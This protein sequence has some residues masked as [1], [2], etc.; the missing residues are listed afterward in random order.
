MILLGCFEILLKEEIIQTLSTEW[1]QELETR[2]NSCTNEDKEKYVF[3]KHT[4]P[5]MFTL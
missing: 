5:S 4:C 2:R 1:S 3:K